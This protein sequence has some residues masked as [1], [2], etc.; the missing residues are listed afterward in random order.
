MSFSSENSDRDGDGNRQ[1]KPPVGFTMV[2]MVV[3]L[4]VACLLMVAVVAFLVNGLVS[5]TKTTAIND[6]TTRGRYI[7]EHLSS[8]MAKSADLSLTNFTTPNSNSTAY[9][10]FNYRINV[11]AAGSTALTPLSSN[12]IQIDFPPATAPEYLVPQA[13]DF[14][15]L[16][17]PSFGSSGTP[18]AGV[19]QSGSTYTITLTDTLAN[20]TGQPANAEVSQY[21][22]ATVQR[23]RSYSIQLNSSTGGTELW[24]Y[25][26]TSNLP[27]NM[28]V[29]TQLPAAQ[30]P[31]VPQVK[32]ANGTTYYLGVQL[33]LAATQGAGVAGE[34]VQIQK[35][36]TSFYTC[37]LYTSRCV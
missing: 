26:A 8:E 35:G 31:F 15:L 17:Y 22:I 2:E 18:I 13:G 37:L 32:I 6:T 1:G 27:S 25:P 30:F 4:G 19:S 21:E 7:F 12:Q 3:G 10:A 11:S 9:S 36:Q 29:A 28:V 23:Q 14:L 5:S 33:A 20:L 34:A 16:P 24:W